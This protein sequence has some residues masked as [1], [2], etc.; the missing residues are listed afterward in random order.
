MRAGMNCTIV[1]G[2]IDSPW[3]GLRWIGIQ[4][5]SLDR[6]ALNTEQQPEV[7][8]PMPD[9]IKRVEQVVQFYVRSRHHHVHTISTMVR[10]QDKLFQRFSLLYNPTT[11]F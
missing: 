8:R 6:H 10:V 4:S 5:V 3:D 9:V 7:E 2:P 1:T 11:S